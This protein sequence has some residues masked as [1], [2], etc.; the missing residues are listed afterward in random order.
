M[1]TFGFEQWLEDSYDAKLFNS[2]EEGIKDCD[3]VMVL[4]IQHERM[5]GS[6]ISSLGEY[7][8]KYGLNHDRFLH[9]KENAIIMHPGPINRN[10]EISSQL[11]DDPR[12]VA[13]DQIKIGVYVRMAILL[14]LRGEI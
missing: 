4:R 5:V 14:Y 1:V 6:Y 8:D 2:I 3:V 12:C 10:V 7:Y 9:A 11:A 13:L